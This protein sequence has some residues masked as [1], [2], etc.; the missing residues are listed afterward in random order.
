MTRAFRGRVP[1]SGDEED[2]AVLGPIPFRVT[3]KAPPGGAAYWKNVGAWEGRTPKR[4]KG[5]SIIGWW[6]PIYQYASVVFTCEHGYVWWE[7]E[8]IPCIPCRTMVRSWRTAN[9]L[10]RPP[11]A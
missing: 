7:Y 10:T 9:A 6:P 1:I 11:S 2:E 8:Q 5:S 3:T 4:Y